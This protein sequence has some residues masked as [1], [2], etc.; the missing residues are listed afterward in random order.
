[1]DFNKLAFDM[2][3]P[4]SQMAYN[5]QI[6]NI[7]R[8]ALPMLP[9]QQAPKEEK[10]TDSPWHKIGMSGIYGLFAPHKLRGLF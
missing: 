6:M 8:R 7:F 10:F 5:P 2:A 4:Q 9:P 1:M 3:Q